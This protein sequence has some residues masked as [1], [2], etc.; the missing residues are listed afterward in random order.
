MFF[1][2]ELTDPEAI[3]EMIAPDDWSW[4]FFN[5]TH[6]DFLEW[7]K[8]GQR[9]IDEHPEFVHSNIW[10]AVGGWKDYK[11]KWLTA[12]EDKKFAHPGPAVGH[13]GKCICINCSIRRLTVSIAFQ[14]ARHLR[15]SKLI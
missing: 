10:V 15:F 14:L 1:T 12:D 4:T 2:S 7:V 8:E 13:R 3:Q 6:Y 5:I 9:L 11:F